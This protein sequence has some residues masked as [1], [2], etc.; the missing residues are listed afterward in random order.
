MT[1]LASP[2]P[3]SLSQTTTKPGRARVWG[4]PHTG[5]LAPEARGPG[6]SPAGQSTQTGRPAASPEGRARPR[7]GLPS[8]R[9]AAPRPARPV[10]P[11]AQPAGAA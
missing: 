3:S 7:T 11:P 5:V 2:T 1:P 8:P 9:S 4:R 10:G 6:P